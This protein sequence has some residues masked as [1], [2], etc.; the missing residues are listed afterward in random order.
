MSTIPTP[1]PRA[2]SAMRGPLGAPDTTFSTLAE[3]AGQERTR[4]SPEA[5]EPGLRRFLGN[6]PR[7]KAALA[8]SRVPRTPGGRQES[9]H[10]Q[11]S[12]H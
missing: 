11:C 10:T 4:F 5:E 3:G 9:P 2:L 12:P 8:G 7:I 6:S 1:P